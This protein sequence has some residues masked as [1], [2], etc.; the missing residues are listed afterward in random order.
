MP[1]LYVIAAI[2]LRLI[3]HPWNM[4]PLGAMFLFSG[5]TFQRK[6]TSLLVPLL[7]LILS[8]IAVVEL[9]YGGRYAWFSPFTWLGFTVV[10]LLGWAL[11]HKFSGLRLLATSLAGSLLFFLISNF[12]V[13]LEGTLYPLTW[14]GLVE[15]YVA[16]IPFFRN[17]L[18]GDL[19]Y[20][21]AMF[22]SYRWLSTR[23][24]HLRL[25]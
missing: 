18:F 11:R 25:G 9:M 6:S 13:W 12:G 24:P 20:A 16:A 8:D 4:T 15:C 5:A 3:P 1:Y 7:A 2:A 22:G 21:A 10:G 19:L 17:S 14:S 23:L